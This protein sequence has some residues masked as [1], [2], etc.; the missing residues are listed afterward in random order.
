MNKPHSL[1]P[2]QKKIFNLFVKMSLPMT[3][4]AFKSKW[5]LTHEEIA[6]ICHCDYSTVARW[7]SVRNP[8][9]PQLH[10]LVYLTL[11]DLFLKYCDSFLKEIKDDS[12]LKEIKDAF[13]KEE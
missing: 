3:H 2:R 4:E 8:Q 12:F 5:D 7:F 11:A 13:F 6:E 1:S 10:H 9:T